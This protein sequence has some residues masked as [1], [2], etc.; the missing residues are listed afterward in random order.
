MLRYVRDAANLVTLAGLACAVVC[1]YF[2]ALGNFPAAMIA[3]IWAC[4]FDW[5][6][7]PV[8]RRQA[9]RTETQR[10]YGKE[11]DSLADMVYTGVAPALLLV[12]YGGWEPWLLPGALLVTAVAAVRLA[13]FNVHGMLDASTYHGL[14]LDINVIVVVALFLFEGTMSSVAFT[15]LLY[16]VLVVLADSRP[17]VTSQ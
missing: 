14:T 3:L 16:S 11:L 7:G 15:R 12:S 9:G 5:L 1:L 8:A 4:A 17:L 6:D 2:T 13:Y 10:T